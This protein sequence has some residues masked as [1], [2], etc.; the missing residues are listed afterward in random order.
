MHFVILILAWVTPA[1]IA[2]MLGWSGIWGSGSAFGEY[3]IPIPVAGGVFH[4][5]SFAIAAGV[6]LASRNSIGPLSRYLPVLAFSMLAL[7]LSLMLEFDRLNAWLFTDYKPSGSPFRLDGNPLL[8]FVA[9]DAFWVGTY[10]LMRGFS[11][12]AKTWYV[13]PLVPLAVIGFSAVHYQTSGPVFKLGGST[14]TTSRGQQIITVYT[15]SS[16]DEEAFVKWIEEDRQLS[17]PWFNVNSE[18]VAV[19]FTNSM[20]SIKWGRFDQV[21]SESTVATICLYEEDRSIIPHRGYYDCFAGRST[22]EQEMADLA[23]SES[24]GLGRDVD[25]WYAR[26][27]LCDGVEIPEAAATDIARIGVCKGMIEVYPRNVSRFTEI[28]GADS[29]QLRFVRAEAATR[30]LVE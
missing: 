15:S 2:G 11:S 24:T 14:Y 23:V 28:Y 10:A 26:L 7:A 18:H 30:G 17:L 20:Q 19:F 8:L 12:P 21:E 13:M 3:L 5:P 25:F 29:E 4:V 27:L 9:T 1:A 22:V 6:I 16:Y